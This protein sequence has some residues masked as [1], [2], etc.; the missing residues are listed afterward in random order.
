[1]TGRKRQ[2]TQVRLILCR[3]L[4]LNHMHDLVRAA[5]RRHFFLAEL[6]T[7]IFLKHEDQLDVLER[8]PSWLR[9]AKKQYYDDTK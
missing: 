3:T 7:K 4:F 8:V 5:Q 6:D 2:R 1:V 9:I